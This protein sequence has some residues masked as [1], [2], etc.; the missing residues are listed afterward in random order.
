MNYIITENKFDSVLK[1]YL[2]TIYGD[3][4]CSVTS[5]SVIWSRNGNPVAG[6]FTE[7]PNYLKLSEEFQQLLKIFS[8]EWDDETD[9]KL[10]NLI[11]PYL[12]FDGG[13]LAIPILQDLGFI[14]ELTVNAIPSNWN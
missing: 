5:D 7:Y 4:T 3:L 9:E 13:S 8:L 1:K 2:D 6:V 12:K 14:E 10:R 11:I